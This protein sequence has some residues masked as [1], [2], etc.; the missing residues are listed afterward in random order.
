MLMTR[1]FHLFWACV[2]LSGSQ[3]NYVNRGIGRNLEKKCIIPLLCGFQRS[4]CTESSICGWSIV[5]PYPIRT[6]FDEMRSHPSD[7]MIRSKDLDHHACRAV[8]IFFQKCVRFHQM[9]IPIDYICFGND[10]CASMTLQQWVSTYLASSTLFFPDSA[11]CWAPNQTQQAG[12]RFGFRFRRKRTTQHTQFVNLFWRMTKN[13]A[14]K[15][16]Q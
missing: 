13:T 11:S 1:A 4:Y 8:A 16:N 2:W 3:A 14:L 7:L 6:F 12:G 5:D 9:F 15:S 10:E